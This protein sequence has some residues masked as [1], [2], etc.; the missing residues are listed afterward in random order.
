MAYSF[1]PLKNDLILR[2]AKGES[3]WTDG[4]M[5]SP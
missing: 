3:W 4:E 1:E 5:P 2:A